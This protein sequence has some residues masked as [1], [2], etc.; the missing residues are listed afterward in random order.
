MSKKDE[1][2][3]RLKKGLSF[4]RIQEEVGCSKSVISYHA[5]KLGLSKRELT[6]YDWQEVQAFH[7]AGHS[8][9]ECMARFGFSPAA[10]SDAVH[11][12]RLKPH[13]HRIPLTELLSVGRGT[14]RTHLKMR[15]LNAG[16]LEYK[17]YNC[18]ISEWHDRRLSLELHHVDGNGMNNRLEN[19]Q[20]LCPN[21][22]S[23]TKTWGGKNR[24]ARDIK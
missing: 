3:A 23:Q 8:R 20:L 18:G 2:V 11:S 1:I 6:Y 21:C 22:H 7:D 19:L 15:L 13:D 5:E 9:Q 4:R 10:W 14:K 12:G 24:K 17:C 16:L